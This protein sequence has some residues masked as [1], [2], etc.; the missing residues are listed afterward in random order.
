MVFGG[1]YSERLKILTQTRAQT[2]KSLPDD[3]LNF[4]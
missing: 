2:V 4:S 3:S 1:L